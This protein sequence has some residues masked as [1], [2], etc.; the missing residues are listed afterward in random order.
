MTF[1]Y[2]WE[3]VGRPA[4]ID[5]LEN[6]PVGS[7]W[8]ATWHATEEM[9]EGLR[10]FLENT[11]NV[12][13]ENV[14][15]RHVRRFLRAWYKDDLAE[16][17][18]LHWI[19][20]EEEVLPPASLPG[21]ACFRISDSTGWVFDPGQ[22]VQFSA[23]VDIQAGAGLDG[24]YPT[25]PVAAPPINNFND[26]RIALKEIKQIAAEMM[27]EPSIDRIRGR[28]ERMLELLQMF[29]DPPEE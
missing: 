15:P 1:E 6:L 10:L 2:W 21:D 16:I 4:A 13:Q 3:N 27:Q 19:D 9:I 18:G 26:P 29:H 12:S 5:Y 23:G 17:L 24:T 11:W 28:A 22:W 20:P 8:H 25:I 14:S 7:P